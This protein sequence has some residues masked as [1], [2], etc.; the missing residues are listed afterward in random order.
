MHNPLEL[1]PGGVWNIA[2]EMAVSAQVTIFNLMSSVY[3]W[4]L[5]DFSDEDDCYAEILKDDIIKLDETSISATLD[6][7]PV[8]AITPEIVQK[9]QEPVESTVS[10]IHPFQGTAN[11]RIRLRKLAA[12][13][14]RGWVLESSTS[15]GDLVGESTSPNSAQSSGVSSS[16]ITVSRH[17]IL[18]VLLVLTFMALF[19]SILGGLWRVRRII[20]NSLYQGF[21]R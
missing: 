5:Q 3:F 12:Q 8:S 7:R 6:I 19:V 4:A 1:A 18:V 11:R 20:Y 2:T 10:Q 13:T 9:S 15:N 14:S 21:L 16:R 17:L